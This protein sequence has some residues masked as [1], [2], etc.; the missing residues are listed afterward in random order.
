MGACIVSS[1]AWAHACEVPDLVHCLHVLRPASAAFAPWHYALPPPLACCPISQQLPSQAARMCKE[2]EGTQNILQ[3]DE[4]DSSMHALH[5][6][7][8]FMPS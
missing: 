2:L 5:A 4:H 6:L 3:P 7:Q 1:S 8:Q